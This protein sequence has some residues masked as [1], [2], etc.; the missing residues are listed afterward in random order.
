MIINWEANNE[1]G[2]DRSV[3]CNLRLHSATIRS[4]T[5]HMSNGIDKNYARENYVSG[6]WIGSTENANEM[7]I[8]REEQKLQAQA[9]SINE[10]KKT[11]W[12]SE[13]VFT[14]WAAS[15]I[16]PPLATH[17][18][19][20]CTGHQFHIILLSFAQLSLHALTPDFS[21]SNVNS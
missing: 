21:I 13:S 14:G 8:K 3:L 9:S 20:S 2:C 15:I 10:N 1:C 16:I 18:P 4:T 17:R 11:V 5:P 6:F 12:L 19:S 7:K